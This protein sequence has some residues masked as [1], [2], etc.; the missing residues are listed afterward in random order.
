M[1]SVAEQ[2]P[3]CAVGWKVEN[4]VAMDGGEVM[5]GHV[6]GMPCR[7][8]PSKC[9]DAITI[10]CDKGT[11]E[12]TINMHTYTVT[13][14]GVVVCLV[15]QVVEYGIASPDFEGRFIAFAKPFLDSIDIE[16]RMSA[17]ISVVNNP[18]AALTR[19]EHKAVSLYY[20]MLQGVIT[21]ASQ[22]NKVAV[23]KHLTAAFFYSIGPSMYKM[24]TIVSKG[25]E[26]LLDRFM[27]LVQDNFREH[28]DLEFYA[29]KMCLTPKYMSTAIRQVSGK[30]AGEWI[31]EYVVL[32]AKALLKST[33]L[34]IQQISNELHF[35]SQSIF[36]TYFKRVVGVSPRTYRNS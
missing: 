34:T 31:E 23:A 22:I 19:E 5:L 13:A 29:D 36:G 24:E 8:D 4:G 17:Y 33:R 6:S 16:G 32:E 20:D 12:V 18:C 11:L 10:I 35:P 2:A 28:R 1:K 21:A 7:R 27:G 25:N 30:T 3:I 14:G 9:S 15:G 26:A